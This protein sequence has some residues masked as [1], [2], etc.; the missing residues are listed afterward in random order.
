[1]DEETG[2]HPKAISYDHRCEEN[3]EYSRLDIRKSVHHHTIQIN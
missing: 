3:I 1:M 2:I